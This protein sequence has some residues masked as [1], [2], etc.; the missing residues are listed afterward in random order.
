LNHSGLFGMEVDEDSSFPVLKINLHSFSSYT[1]FFISILDVF[2]RWRM[3][4]LIR[5]KL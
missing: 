3:F 4:I 5:E 1:D 2:R